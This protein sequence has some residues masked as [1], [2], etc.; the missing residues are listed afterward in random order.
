MLVSIPTLPTTTT[1]T[2]R[3]PS[4]PRDWRCPL[5]TGHGEPSRARRRHDGHQDQLPDNDRALYQPNHDPVLVDVPPSS[6]WPSTATGTPAP[7][8]GTPPPSRRCPPPPRLSG[9][10]SRR[11]PA[12]T[13]TCCPAGPVVGRR[14]AGVHQP[15][16]VALAVDH[17]HPPAGPVGGEQ[18]AA[19]RGKARAKAG[20]ITDVLHPVT[21]EEGRS[22]QRMH[23]G[24]MP[25][26]IPASCRLHQ[27]IAANGPRPRQAPRDLPQRPGA[28]PPDR[29]RT[30][31]R[32]PVQPA[33]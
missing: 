5:R 17:A 32:Q 23:H 22:A 9:S 3:A 27:F 12:T 1:S 7:H 11:P 13:T 19:A 18:A 6:C 33:R 29:M 16:Q 24:R 14:L 21:L 15:R 4:L 25:P 28:H 10:P 26:S 2:T 30:V 31:L 20:P 8:L